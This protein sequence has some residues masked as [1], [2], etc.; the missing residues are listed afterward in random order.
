MLRL[1][2]LVTAII[3]FL[4][5]AFPQNFAFV[6]KSGAVLGINQL[7]ATVNKQTVAT[8]LQIYCINHSQLPNKLNDLFGNELDPKSYLDLDKIFLL[9][10][11][12]DCDFELTTK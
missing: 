6:K 5:F 9:K 4:H 10:K 12:K 3:S 11:I 7:E 8:A 1:T 2:L